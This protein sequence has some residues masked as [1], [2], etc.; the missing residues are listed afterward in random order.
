MSS[1][2][3]SAA[4][5]GVDAFEVEVEVHAGNRFCGRNA[6][7][8]PTRNTAAKERAGQE[9]LGSDNLFGNFL[10]LPAF[11]FDAP[12]AK[13]FAVVRRVTRQFQRRERQSNYTVEGFRE[14]ISGR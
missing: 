11:R 8:Q 12:P 10:Q 14:A 6:R 13:R 7:K 5:L 9:G 4:V 2:A 3:Y 1:K